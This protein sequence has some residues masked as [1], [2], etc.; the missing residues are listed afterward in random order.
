MLLINW[1]WGGMGVVLH[2]GRALAYI[3]KYHWFFSHAGPLVAD[4]NTLG[5]FILC[6]IDIR[7][8]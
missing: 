7:H 2:T 8:D 3:E 6:L 1:G 4:L 5:P